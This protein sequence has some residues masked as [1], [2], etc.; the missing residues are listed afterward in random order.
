MGIKRYI[1]NLDT[2]ITNAFKPNLLTRATGANMGAADVMEIFSIYGQ[3]YLSGTLT[4]F[5]Q[6]QELSRILVQFPVTTIESDRNNVIIPESGS[7]SFYL[8]LFNAK[9]SQTTPRD[10]VYV[11]TPVSRS[12]EEGYGMDL[13]DY[14]DL[15]KDNTGANWIN[16]EANTSWTAIGGDYL[17]SSAQSQSLA[18][19]TEDIEVDITAIVENWI[20]GSSGAVNATATITLNS[21]AASDYDDET[22][23]VQSTDGTEVV[24]TLDD[25][26]GTNTYGAS[27]TNIGIQGGPSAPWIVGKIEDAIINSSNAHYNKISVDKDSA[28]AATATMQFNSDTAG[29][30]D[31]ETF[32]VT[33]T[34]GTEV[35]YTLNDDSTSNTYAPTATSI[36]I[37]G[38]P[39][40]SKV[41]ELATAAGNNSSNAHYGKITWVEGASATVTLTQDVS[42]QPGN[43]TITTTDSTDMTV[44]GFSGGTGA[45]LTLTQV[46]DGTGGNNTVATSDATDITVSGF[47]G[48][49]TGF[50]NYGL[51]I[52]LTSSQEAY[53]S[54]S[55][56]VDSGSSIQNPNGAKRSYYTKKIFGRNSQFFFKRPFIEARWDSSVKDD[57]NK[58]HYSSSLLS[59]NDSLNKLFLYIYVNGQLKSLPPPYSTS[60]GALT[61]PVFV[62]LF[63]GSLDNTLPTGSALTV[64]STVTNVDSST[65]T[66]ISGGYV[67]ANQQPLPNTVGIYSASFALTASSTPLTRV[68]DVWYLNESGVPGTI[69]H[70]GSFTPNVFKAS[71]AGTQSEY[72]F[73]ISNLKD[74]YLEKE[75]TRIRLFARQRDWNPS[76]YTV[77]NADPL[78]YTLEDVYY[79][80]MRELDGVE[81][82]TFGTGSTTP[83]SSGNPGSYTR[84]SYDVSG[85]YFDLDMSL[86]EPGY[87]YQMEFVYFNNNQYTKVKEKFRFRVEEDLDG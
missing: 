68:F 38:A 24:Y 47:T 80:I 87:S 44:S 79:K 3:M 8:R 72:T 42:G 25:D 81:A 2:T 82:I 73:N 13:D 10:A 84:L 53:F 48:G 18:K 46:I 34:D 22:F 32:T 43:N 69:I 28:A 1:A 45:E 76:I 11:V 20:R 5:A 56:G 65:P 30:Y 85:S 75:T 74:V 15:T 21:N 66:V 39:A 86:F 83:Q 55:A 36:G 27:T 71:I 70:T 41:A 31:D 60:D 14:T 37:Q 63:S 64:I 59:A 26:T 52:H 4:G 19:G 7:V 35:V 6:T 51:G 57:R 16:S 78:N 61:P 23:T 58:T 77:A 62:K 67:L 50:E 40:A 17:T 54:S 9:Q 33:S 29:D 12:W 49:L